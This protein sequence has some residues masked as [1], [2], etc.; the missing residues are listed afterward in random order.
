MKCILIYFIWKKREDIFFWSYQSYNLL[1][2]RNNKTKKDINETYNNEGSLTNH[3]NIEYGQ[4]CCHSCLKSLWQSRMGRGK[5]VENHTIIG[6]VICDV[7]YFIPCFY[8]PRWSFLFT[9]I[10]LRIIKKKND[11]HQISTHRPM[12]WSRNPK[13]PLFPVLC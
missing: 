12:V 10:F 6:D 1:H 9:Y 2:Q 8:E 5:A 13:S 3:I 4:K 7:L 11:F